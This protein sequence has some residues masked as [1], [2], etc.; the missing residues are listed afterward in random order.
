MSLSKP[1]TSRR[2]SLLPTLSG[3]TA[4]R[5]TERN[6]I[7]RDLPPADFASLRE[8]LEIVALTHGTLLAEAR[9]PI[10]HVYFPL[11]AVVSLLTPMPNAAAVEIALVG[12]D[13]MVGVSL[14]AGARDSATR[15]VVQVS[16]DAYRMSARTFLHLRETSDALDQIT[17]RY[18]NTLLEQIAQCAACSQRH[19]VGARCARWMLMAQDRVGTN[20][21][22]LT[23]EFLGEMLDVKRQ[24]VS[25][26]ASRLQRAGLIRYS[27][28]QLT[29]TN[30]AGLERAACD[31]YRIIAGDEARALVTRRR[32]A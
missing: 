27:R 28:G 1:N 32:S 25:V 6:R 22:G 15:A 3:K 30:R 2:A 31:C 20:H 17:R 26:A 5:R 10:V 29:I 16:G 14:V 4:G 7:L 8:R 21:F 19:A 18:A 9:E 13:G 24:S 23:Q 12:A 11:T